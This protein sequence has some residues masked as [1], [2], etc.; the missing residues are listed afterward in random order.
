[1]RSPDRYYFVV[2]RI[3]AMPPNMYLTFCGKEFSPHCTTT[4]SHYSAVCSSRR[5]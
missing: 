3:L 1:V 2:V 5:E 4:H